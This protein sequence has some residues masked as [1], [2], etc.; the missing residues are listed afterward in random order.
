[1]ARCDYDVPFGV[2]FMFLVLIA[3][4]RAIPRAD[5]DARVTGKA[6][7]GRLARHDVVRSGRIVSFEQFADA[8]GVRTAMQWADHGDPIAAVPT[9]SAIPT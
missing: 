7:D 4:Y 3:N 5:E 9:P 6:L 2:A 8:A 1:M